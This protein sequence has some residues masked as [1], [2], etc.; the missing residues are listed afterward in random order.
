MANFRLFGANRKQTFV[1]PWS[2]N[3]KT[4]I[5]DFC[6]SKRAHLCCWECFFFY[7]LHVRIP[8]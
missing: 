8:R 7:S 6:F 5:D 2:A 3:A 4:V 1:F